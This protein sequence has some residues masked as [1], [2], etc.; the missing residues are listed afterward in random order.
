M[1]PTKITLLIVKLLLKTDNV[2]TFP[3][4]FPL[5]KV[6]S[7]KDHTFMVQLAVLTKS[8]SYR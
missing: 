8:E 7:G 6:S 2:E 3:L 5:V 1:N 4:S